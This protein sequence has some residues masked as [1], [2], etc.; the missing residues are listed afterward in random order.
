MAKATQRRRGSFWAYS[1]RGTRVHYYH[2]T[3]ARHQAPGMVAETVA[4]NS[5]R[6]QQTGSRE[7]SLG[8]LK[9]Y[10]SDVLPPAST[11]P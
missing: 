8:N 10:L 6:E 3:E 2:G 1:C 7:S 9:A 11:A 4:K 5:H